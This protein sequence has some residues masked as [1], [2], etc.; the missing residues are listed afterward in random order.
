MWVVGVATDGTIRRNTTIRK[1]TVH[2]TP[3]TADK[4]LIDR[5]FSSTDEIRRGFFKWDLSNPVPLS[6]HLPLGG[7]KVKGPRDSSDG[8]WMVKFAFFNAQ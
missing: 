4:N 5:C 1:S 7:L 8:S 6:V 3:L 2:A